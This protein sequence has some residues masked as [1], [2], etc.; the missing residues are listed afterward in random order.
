MIFGLLAVFFTDSCRTLFAHLGGA[1]EAWGNSVYFPR[2]ALV[3]ARIHAQTPVS[4][5]CLLTYN[6]H[7]LAQWKNLDICQGLVN[8]GKEFKLPIKLEF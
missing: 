5:N 4:R 7:H 2:G 6:A 1:A 3:V 8:F